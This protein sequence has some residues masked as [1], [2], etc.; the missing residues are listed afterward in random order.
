MFRAELRNFSS[1]DRIQFIAPVNGL[2]VANR[3][4][5]IIESM[6]SD[7]RLHLQMDDGR[8]VALDSN[9]HVHLDFGYAVTSHSSQGQPADRVLIQVDT[10][11][12]AKDLL[13]SRMAY[14]AVSRGAHDA[15]IFTND[16][17]ALGLTL[18][19]DVSHAPAIQQNPASQAIG[20]KQN[21]THEIGPGFGMGM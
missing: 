5:G 10:K 7:G 18:S 3:E 11:L 19:R 6:S 13:N 21:Y 17:T 12:G 20:Q 9:R 4:L 16:E 2:K 8:A 14:V 15:Q 1:G